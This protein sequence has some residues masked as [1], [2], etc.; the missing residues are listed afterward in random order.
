MTG[1]HDNQLT[2]GAP[3]RLVEIVHRIEAEQG[4][5][6][7][8]AVL[9]R[10]SRPLDAPGPNRALS[11]AWLGHALHPLM[12]DFPLGC[13]MSATLLD[14]FG[15]RRS[16]PAAQGLVAF[17][18]ACAVPTIASGVVEWRRTATPDRRVGVVHAAINGLA[19]ACYARSMVP[20][21]RGQG[22]R[23]A[24]WSVSGGL[25]ATAGGY[26]GGHLSIARKI[27]SRDAAMTEPRSPDGER[28]TEPALTRN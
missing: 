24:T 13:W 10:V 23:A 26:L 8:A 20:R 28:Q 2:E 27:G 6:G 9:D 7:P 18:V 25:L 15:G 3:A 11:G 16:R 14:L 17:G 5:D 22:F 12:T 1:G 21:A 19:G 4:L